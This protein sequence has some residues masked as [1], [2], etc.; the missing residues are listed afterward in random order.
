VEIKG[1]WPRLPFEAKQHLRARLR[2]PLDTVAQDALLAAGVLP[3][4][5]AGAR[6]RRL[7][8]SDDDWTWIEQH[9]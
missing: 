5:P 6:D 1:W 3:S 8:L 2:E 9:G 4:D 7:V